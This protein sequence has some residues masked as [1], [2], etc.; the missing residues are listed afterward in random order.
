MSV[1]F[2]SSIFDRI[3]PR[4]VGQRLSNRRIF[5][6]WDRSTWQLGKKKAVVHGFRLFGTFATARLS[7]CDASKPTLIA[8]IGI[9]KSATH[10]I[11]DSI[12]ASVSLLM[13]H[14]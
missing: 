1:Q 8:R 10:L 3:L 12:F 13:S 9:S 7:N 14:P 11:W 2:I 5:Y 6:N 4:G